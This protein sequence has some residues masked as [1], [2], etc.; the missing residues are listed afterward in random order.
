MAAFTHFT[1]DVFAPHLLSFQR[2]LIQRYADIG[3]SG[4]CKDEWGFPPCYDGCP[5][6]NDFWYSKAYAAAYEKATGGR[7]LVADCLLM[8]LGEPGREAE[9]QAAINHFLKLSTQRNGAIEDDFGRSA[10]TRK[11]DKNPKRQ[12][13]KAASL[14]LFEAAHVS[15]PSSI[16]NAQSLTS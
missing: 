6:K 1:P 11:P 7:D 14:A 4:V 13:M 5:A 8:H 16:H 10:Y 12:Q 9:R 2:E 3:M 15:P